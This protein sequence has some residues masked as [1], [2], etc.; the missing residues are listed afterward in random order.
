MLGLGCSEFRMQVHLDMFNVFETESTHF[1]VYKFNV[2]ETQIVNRIVK[3][4]NVFENQIVLNKTIK[5]LSK[6]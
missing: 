1:I 2:F 3:L 5:L 4:L 6:N